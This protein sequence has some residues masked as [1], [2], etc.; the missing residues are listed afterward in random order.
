MTIVIDHGYNRFHHHPGER[1]VKGPGGKEPHAR[2]VKASEFKA[3]CLQMMDEVAATGREIVITKYGRPVSRLVPCR[4]KP[5]SV[6]GVDRDVIQVHGDL[7][8]PLPL[9]WDAETDRPVDTDRLV[10]TGGPV[11]A[12]RPVDSE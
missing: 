8:E 10:D 3:K 11:D 4:E 7:M 2:S 5:Q 6:F 1:A 12:Y 9:V